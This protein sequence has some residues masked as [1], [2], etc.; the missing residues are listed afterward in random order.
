MRTMLVYTKTF[1]AGLIE[2]VVLLFFML[3]TGD[4]FMAKLVR[5][6]PTLHDKKKAVGIAE[7]V[8]QNLSTFLFTITLINAVL[9]GLIGLAAWSLGLP[10]PALWGALAGLLNFIPYFG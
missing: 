2:T 4:L 8:Q 5:V 6:L 1:L 7:E 3:A 10:N 9:G